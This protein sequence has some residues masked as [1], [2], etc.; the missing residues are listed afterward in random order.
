MKENKQLKA[1]KWSLIIIMTA[2]RQ[3]QEFDIVIFHYPWVTKTLNG[4]NYP[5]FLFF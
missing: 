1:S 2:V 5:G 4:K 3:V